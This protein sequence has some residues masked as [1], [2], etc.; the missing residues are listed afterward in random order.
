MHPDYIESW[1]DTLHQL[2]KPLRE[3]AELNVKTFQKI[4]YLKPDELSQLK[5]PE[6]FLEKNV[7]IFIHNS[8]KML[9][10]MQQAFDIFEKQ[11]LS[12]ANDINNR[13]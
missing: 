6:D 9:D 11:L 2:Q 4:S 13:H 7:H 5:N 10:Y 3:L 1:K 8:H 12:V